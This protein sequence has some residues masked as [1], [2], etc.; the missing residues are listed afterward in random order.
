MDVESMMSPIY[1]YT[2]IKRLRFTGAAILEIVHN[3]QFKLIDMLRAGIEWQPCSRLGQQLNPI[4][5]LKGSNFTTRCE[6]DLPL[7]AAS[8]SV[9][10]MT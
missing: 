8:K 4:Q 1:S 5:P 3:Q 6:C 9:F 10:P 2:S 7:Q